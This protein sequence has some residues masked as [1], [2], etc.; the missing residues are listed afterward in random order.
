MQVGLATG[1]GALGAGWLSHC[2]LL[3]PRLPSAFLLSPAL[4]PQVQHVVSQNCD[5]LHLR[6]GLPRSAI[7]E[8]HGNMYIEVSSP[9]AGGPGGP[10]PALTVPSLLRSAR[11]ALPTGST[12]G[13]ST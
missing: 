12:C 10:A 6:S 8:L 2:L 3:P 1:L 7:S 5:G 11:P 13:C 4:S 9:G